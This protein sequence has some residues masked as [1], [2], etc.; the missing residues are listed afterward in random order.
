MESSFAIFHSYGYWGLF[1]FAFAFLRIFNFPSTARFTL[2]R[3]SD[4][5][6]QMLLISTMYI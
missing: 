6:G 4:S 2:R 1:G 5:S 3:F